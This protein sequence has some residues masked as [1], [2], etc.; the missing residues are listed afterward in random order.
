MAFSSAMVICAVK[1]A[2][3]VSSLAVKRPPR[4]LSAWWTPMQSPD[5][6]MIGMARMDSVR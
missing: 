2:S 4:L 5:L 6:L 3:R 1:A